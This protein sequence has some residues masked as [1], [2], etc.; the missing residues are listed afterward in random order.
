MGTETGIA[1]GVGAA[2][3]LWL[4]AGGCKL[5][6]PLDVQSAEP[7]DV[8]ITEVMINPAA[9]ADHVGEWVEVY[10]PGNRDVDLDGMFLKSKTGSAGEIIGTVDYTAIVPGG[11]WAVIARR[12]EQNFASPEISPIAYWGQDPGLDDDDG[13]QISIIGSKGTLDQTYSMGQ[14]EADEGVAWQLDPSSLEAIR[15]DT[16]TAWCSAVTEMDNGDLGTP[17]TINDL[18]D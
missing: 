4:G 14:A 7:G 17:G 8:V 18:C 5:D 15:N 16:P 1:R 9:V 11:G 10:V 12:D 2:V 6:F 13:E 3:A